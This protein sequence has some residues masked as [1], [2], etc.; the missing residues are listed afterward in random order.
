MQF[1]KKRYVGYAGEAFVVGMR[2]VQ[3]LTHS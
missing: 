3:L 1:Q 2:K